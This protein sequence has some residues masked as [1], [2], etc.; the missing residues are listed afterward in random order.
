VVDTSLFD[1]AISWVDIQLNA[2]LLDGEAPKRH[3]TASATLA[4]YQVFETADRPICIAAGNDRLFGRCADVLGHPEWISDERFA[5]VQD[6]SAHRPALIALM[7]PVLKTRSAAEWLTALKRVGVPV[8]PV[9][10]IPELAATEQLA[11]ADMVRTMPHSGLKVTGL[12]IMFDGERPHPT[13]NTPKLGAH[14]D[15]ILTASVAAE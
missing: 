15:E 13:Q 7:Q 12:P 14:N 10:D 6:R 11:A 2:F 3:G 1:S 8:S 4:P 5:R 9:N